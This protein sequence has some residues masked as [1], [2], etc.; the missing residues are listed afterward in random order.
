M[1]LGAIVV[2]GDS[3]SPVSA[4]PATGAKF[5][6][7]LAYLDVLGRSTAER[8]VEK[9]G[10]ADVEAVCVLREKGGSSESKPSFT[11]FENVEFQE[12]DN[13]RSAIQS[14]LQEYSRNGIEHA[15]LLFGNIYAETDLLDF[16]YFHRE[17]RQKVTRSINRDGVLDLWVVDCKRGQDVDLSEL[18][19][20]TTK[21]ANSYFIREYV[22]RLMSPGDLRRFASDSL[23]GRCSVRPSGREV[24]RGIWIDVEAEVHRRAR[25]VAPAY[26]GR[27]SKVME[28]TLITRS[29]N[30]ERDCCVDYGT[31]IEDSSIL[32]NT[33]VGICLD[34]CHGIANGNKLLK[35]DRD[36]VIEISDPA[37][38]RSN[39]PVPR[40]AKDRK[41]AR[42]VLSFSRRK[43]ERQTAATPQPAASAP[44]PR[45]LHVN[46]SRGE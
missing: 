31:V 8:I 28:D 13:P 27:R 12:A 19:A 20:E 39:S 40:L 21:S 5:A 22:N 6:E 15:F 3:G 30:I 4:S 16:F 23:Q 18:L 36:V 26:I 34:V 33:E 10:R 14:K 24:K 17:S 42:N 46:S 2:L 9:F 41:W 38:M 44:E 1:G 29:S 7:P 25:I 43:P 45:R 11:A 37:V 35:L 32:Q